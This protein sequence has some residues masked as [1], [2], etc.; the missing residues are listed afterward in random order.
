MV[1]NSHLRRKAKDLVLENPVW[2]PLEARSK[3]SHK[4][5]LSTSGKV[6]PDHSDQAKSGKDSE[7]SEEAQMSRWQQS[8]KVRKSA[9]DIKSEPESDASMSKVLKTWNLRQNLQKVLPRGCPGEPVFL[10]LHEVFF[11]QLK[12]IGVQCSQRFYNI[13]KNKGGRPEIPIPMLAIVCTA[14]RATLLAKRNKSS[15]DFKFTGNQFLDIYNHHMSLLGSIQKKAPIKFH[16][17]MSD[18]YEEV[19]RFRHSISGAYN[20]DD[21]LSFLDLDSMDD[22]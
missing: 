4:H 5:E 10:I 15:D 13:V 20:Q 6:S 14:I 12:S 11:K 21:S 16:K 17:M 2:Q 9:I 18:I 1:S 3:Q 8:K 7:D 19:N 22:E